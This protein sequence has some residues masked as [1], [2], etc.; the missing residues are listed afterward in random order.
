VAFFTPDMGNKTHAARIVLIGV[1]IET[2][3]L[4]MLDFGSRGH[5]ALLKMTVDNEDTALQQRCQAKQMGSDSYFVQ[6]IFWRT[7]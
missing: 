6:P 4:K 7:Y 3:F 2:V 5:G 1:G